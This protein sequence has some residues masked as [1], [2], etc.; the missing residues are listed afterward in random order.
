MSFRTN[1]LTY[2]WQVKYCYRFFPNPGCPHAPMFQ[3]FWLLTRHFPQSLAPKVF[4]TKSL[5][6][7]LQ[8]LNPFTNAHSRH[9]PL[10]PLSF[11]LTLHFVQ[12]LFLATLRIVFGPS[13]L[14]Q[15]PVWPWVI[16]SERELCRYRPLKIFSYKVTSISYRP[17]VL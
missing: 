1:L 13:L 6:H 9:S 14:N 11:L 4:C 7:L 2:D 15:W 5:L 3:P 8:A 12:N 16:K 17:T 10:V